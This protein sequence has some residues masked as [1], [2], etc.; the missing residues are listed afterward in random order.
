MA[1]KKIAAKANATTNKVATTKKK[2]ATGKVAPKKATPK[3]K[4]KTAPKTTKGKKTVE[5]EPEKKKGVL[6]KIA[7]AATGVIALVGGIAI[8]SAGKKNAEEEAYLAGQES[9]KAALP[10]NSNATDQ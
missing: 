4:V 7:L 2:V 1:A 8:G 9:A 3:V 5:E 6:G 10:D